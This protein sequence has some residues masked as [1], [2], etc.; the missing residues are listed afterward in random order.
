MLLS[1]PNSNGKMILTT[2]VI[3]IMLIIKVATIALN[4]PDLLCFILIDSE[5]E[6]YILMIF[7]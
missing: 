5:I 6:S 2:M 7:K 4:C 3:I 1:S